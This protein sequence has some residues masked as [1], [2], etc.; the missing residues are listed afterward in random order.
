MVWKFQSSHPREPMVWPTSTTSTLKHS[1]GEK[2][3]SIGS[4]AY[5]PIFASQH[6]R[7]LPLLEQ[8]RTGFGTLSAFVKVKAL[9]R[10]SASSGGRNR[11]TMNC[12]RSEFKI[13][14]E[15]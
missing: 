8:A 1:E 14:T 12:G 13:A 5:K 10:A 11:F 4:R 9:A 2:F 3:A 7:E 6:S 15:R